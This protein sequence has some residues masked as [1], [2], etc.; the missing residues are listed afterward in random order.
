MGDRAAAL[1]F[2]KSGEESAKQRGDQKLVDHGYQLIASA[3]Y[4]D[5]TY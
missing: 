3:C 2:L 1:Q 5:P 4:A